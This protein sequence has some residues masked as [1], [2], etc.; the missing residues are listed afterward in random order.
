MAKYFSQNFHC[1]NIFNIFPDIIHF[2]FIALKDI[3][4][5]YVY[6]SET[7]CK[8]KHLNMRIKA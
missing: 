3:L 2:E 8:D 5:V 1:A 7:L 4:D 6:A